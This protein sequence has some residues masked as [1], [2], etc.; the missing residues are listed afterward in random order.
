MMKQHRS[1][2]LL[3]LFLGIFV[4]L[5]V[6]KNDLLKPDVGQALAHSAEIHVQAKAVPL[7]KDDPAQQTIGKLTYLGGWVLSSPHERFGGLSGLV[8][9][10]NGR[11]LAISDQGDWFTARF[12]PTSD[13][14]LTEAGLHPF[15]PDVGGGGK[16]DF[17]AESLIRAGDEYLVSFEQQHRL[18]LAAPG[19]QARDWPNGNLMDFSGL[20]NNSGL[21]AINWTADGKLL[22][23][24]ERGL[25]T[26]GR[27]RVWLVGDDGAEILFFRPPAN[28]APTDSALL[29][30]GDILV[31]A[32]FFS[33]A[34]GVKVKLLRIKADDVR[35]GNTFS[36]AE[37]A[38]LEPPLLVDNLEGLDVHRS[39]DGSVI[40]YMVSDDNFNASQRTLLMTFRLDQP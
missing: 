29:P 7:N 17:D 37:L 16:V 2:I 24:A 35:A 33:L 30:N 34:N 12:D 13:P 15:Q 38:H 22:A 1:N 21:E 25:D 9:K 23:F 36:G 32:R 10:E 8:M 11:L 28:F 26:Q 27:L 6:F 14:V 3:A 19:M 4:L 18:V 31:L 40:V 20:A 39:A 5:F